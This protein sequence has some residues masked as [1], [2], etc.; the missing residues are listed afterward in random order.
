MGSGFDRRVI[1]FLLCNEDEGGD[2]GY[3]RKILL[4]LTRY[5]KFLGIC[6]MP[7]LPP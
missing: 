1:P 2:D 7:L 4:S 6:K 3:A 5:T